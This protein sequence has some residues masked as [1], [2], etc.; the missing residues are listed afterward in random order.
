MVRMVQ[1][2]FVQAISRI[3]SSKFKQM[4]NQL[5]C[6]GTDTCLVQLESVLRVLHAA[7]AV[8]DRI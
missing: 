5:F 6:C 3:V 8:W 7:A 1:W 2:C 4:K